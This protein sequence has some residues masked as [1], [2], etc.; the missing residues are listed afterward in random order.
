[1]PDGDEALPDPHDYLRE[2]RAFLGRRVGDAILLGE[3]NLPHKEQ[4]QFFG[5]DRAATS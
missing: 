5:G 4:L 2:L 1:M 3:V